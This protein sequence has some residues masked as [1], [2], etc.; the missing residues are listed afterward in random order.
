MIQTLEWGVVVLLLTG[1]GVAVF[2][3][4]DAPPQ[5]ENHSPACGDVIRLWSAGKEISP[6]FLEALF[7]G[8]QAEWGNGNANETWVCAGERYWNGAWKKGG[9]KISPRE[10][11][12]RYE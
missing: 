1:W 7:P 6:A 3:S 9:V 11:H 10:S 4:L 2:S 12:Q 8:L 5:I